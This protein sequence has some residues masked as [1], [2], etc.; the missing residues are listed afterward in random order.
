MSRKLPQEPE[1]VSHGPKLATRL[2]SYQGSIGSHVEMSL[3]YERDR[4]E[5]WQEKYEKLKQETN[6][7]AV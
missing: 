6:R 3:Q 2:W 7:E 4:A 5:Y 1:A